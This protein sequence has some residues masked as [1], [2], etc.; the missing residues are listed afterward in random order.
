LV[1]VLR[2]NTLHLQRVLP[3]WKHA[4]HDWWCSCRRCVSIPSGIV[5][6]WVDCKPLDAKFIIGIRSVMFV[7]GYELR[8]QGVV[9]HAM[10]IYSVGGCMYKSYSF[11]TSH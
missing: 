5:M 4:R 2:F 7:I 10:N 1:A 11:L 6:Q 9:V 8:R 3:K